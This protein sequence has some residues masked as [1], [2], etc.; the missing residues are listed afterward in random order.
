MSE[1]VPVNSVKNVSNPSSEIL[2]PD[3]MIIVPLGVDYWEFPDKAT[4]K[5]IVGGRVQFTLPVQSSGNTRRKGFEIYQMDVSYE[6][7]DSF[8]Y[9]RQNL[10]KLQP[11]NKKI[12]KSYITTF[13]ILE[14]KSR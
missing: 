6:A 12:D 3:K 10:V 1:T 14:A 7:L 5:M 4:G 13:K 8:A 9:Q 2:L 11:I